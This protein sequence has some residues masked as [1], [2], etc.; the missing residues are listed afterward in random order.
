MCV[1]SPGGGG[2]GG[3]ADP[4]LMT[5]VYPYD[6]AAHAPNS[7]GRS[8]GSQTPGDPAT[9]GALDDEELFI[10]EGSKNWRSTPAQPGGAR[11]MPQMRRNPPPHSEDLV[12]EAT[13]NKHNRDIGHLFTKLQLRNLHGILYCL[14]HGTAPVAA[15]QRARRQSNREL[16]L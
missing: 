1:H 9:L 16:Y 3:G 13:A 12:D 7:G 11:K 8:P 15:Q 2:G 14:N 10:V 6:I 4:V 5:C